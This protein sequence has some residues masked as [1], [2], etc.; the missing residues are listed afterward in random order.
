MEIF[1]SSERKHEKKKNLL[2]W[3]KKK[4]TEWRKAV[5]KNTACKSSIE[6]NRKGERD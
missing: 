2:N 4:G 6:K 3:K 1:I 5:K